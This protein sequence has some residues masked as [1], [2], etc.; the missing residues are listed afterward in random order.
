MTERT[1]FLGVSSRRSCRSSQ[2]R[3]SSASALLVGAQ[4]CITVAV[5]VAVETSRH[6]SA[7]FETAPGA[8]LQTLSRL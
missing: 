6:G 5:R 1:S 3:S 7:A 4:T 2:K 8:A